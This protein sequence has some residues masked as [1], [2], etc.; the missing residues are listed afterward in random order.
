MSNAIVNKYQ[1]IS[2]YLQRVRGRI[3]YVYPKD[4]PLSREQFF[5]GCVSMIKKDR[6]GKQSL[7]SC[8][9]ESIAKSLIFAAKLGLSPDPDEKKFYLLPFKGEATPCVGYLGYLEL[10]Y[11]EFPDTSVCS[12][13]VHEGETFY[14]DLG[15]ERKVKHEAGFFT[16]KPAIGAYAIIVLPNGNKEI[17]RMSTESIEKIRGTKKGPWVTDW[18]AMARKTVLKR[19]VKYLPLGST[20]RNAASAEE[21]MEAGVHTV[22]DYIDAEL[23]TTVEST[24]GQRMMEEL[25]GR[26]KK[27]TRAV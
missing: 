10:I 8:K 18:Q 25:N 7:M 22:D 1:D 23:E 19:M 5:A 24:Q 26:I 9:P 13:V 21:Y 2:D 17:E 11:R 15:S 27:E 6:S 16:H 4:C 3:D 20:A 12:Q 14:I